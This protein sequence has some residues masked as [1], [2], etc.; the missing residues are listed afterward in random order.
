MDKSHFETPHE[1]FG[2]ELTAAYI[3]PEEDKQKLKKSSEEYKYLIISLVSGEV[4]IYKC[5]Q[6]TDEIVRSAKIGDLK[7]IDPSEIDEYDEFIQ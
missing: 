5:K 2:W 6:L 3:H 1:K 4:E 7:V